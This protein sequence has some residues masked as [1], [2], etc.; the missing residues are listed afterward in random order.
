MTITKAQR[1]FSV[2]HAMAAAI[3]LGGCLMSYPLYA[4]NTGHNR[5][6]NGQDSRYENSE[7]R[8]RDS[9]D[10]HYAD[11]RDRNSR[12]MRSSDRSA[13]YRDSGRGDSRNRDD[14]YYDKSDH[15]SSG[16][17]HPGYRD[18]EDYDYHRDYE[19][20]YGA[21]YV[22]EYDTSDDDEWERPH[23]DFFG[24]DDAGEKGAWDW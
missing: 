9:R 22:Y 13:G 18:P 7:Y 17:G 21:D 5:G 24:Y 4:E 8:D 20:N 16:Y 1:P 23:R 2:K 12:N 19:S 3:F 15:W 14:S 6:H 11:S 10:S